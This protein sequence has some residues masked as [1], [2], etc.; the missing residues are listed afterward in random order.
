[1]TPQEVADLLRRTVQAESGRT[2]VVLSDPSI[3]STATVCVQDPA[4]PMY[5]LRYAPALESELPYLV[6]FEC[7]MLLR[8]VRADAGFRFDVVSTAKMG[9]EVHLLVAEHLR[10]T[11]PGIADSLVTQAAGQLGNGLGVQL[12]SMPIAIRVDDFLRGEYPMLAEMQQVNVER[13]L[14][15]AMQSLGTAVRNFAPPR[16]LDASSAMNCAFAMFWGRTW[17]RPELAVPFLSAGFG[18]IGTKLLELVSSIGSTPNG[19]RQLVEQWTSL[20]S[21]GEWYQTRTKA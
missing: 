14:Q 10:K 15:N 17:N 21:L 2:V 8:T 1:M 5:T 7:M 6:A 19:D 18:A 12:R 4:T 16:L 9:R 20:L 11:H 3:Q 13:Q